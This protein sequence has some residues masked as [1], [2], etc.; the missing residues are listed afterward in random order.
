MNISLNLQ[1]SRNTCNYNKKSHQY[2]SN[3]NHGTPKTARKRRKLGETRKNSSLFWRLQRKTNQR[4]YI[5]S[6]NF[7]RPGET[8]K[9]ARPTRTGR[10]EPAAS[11]LLPGPAVYPVILPND[12]NTHTPTHTT[13]DRSFAT[14]HRFQQQLAPSNARPQLNTRTGQHAR[15]RIVRTWTS[16]DA[17]ED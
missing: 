1:Y 12:R 8:R 2:N 16:L 15:Y 9:N 4:Q 3:R 17:D 7:Q 6:K 14:R 10:T 11:R 5:T 13:A